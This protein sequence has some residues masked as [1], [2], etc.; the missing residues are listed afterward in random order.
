MEENFKGGGVGGEN[1]EFRNTA[2]ERF[3]RCGEA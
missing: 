1:N 3:G 2:V